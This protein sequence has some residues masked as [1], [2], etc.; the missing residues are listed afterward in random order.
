MARNGSG[1][2]IIP[3]TFNAGSTITSS[4]HNQNYTD[5]A[6]EIT[7]SLALDGQSTMTG[8]IKAANGSAGA[9]AY[10]FGSNLTTGFWRK[11]LN[12]IGIAIAGIEIGSFDANGLNLN[13]IALSSGQLTPSGTVVFTIKTV[14]PIGWLLFNDGTIGD[15]NSG[16]NHANADSLSV[17]TDLFN[18]ISDANCPIL[19]SIGAATTRVAQIDAATAWAAHCRITLPKSL[20]RALA[21]AGSGSGLTT[22]TLGATAGE[23]NHTLTQSE[24]SIALGTATSNSVVTDPGHYHTL[25][26]G[27]AGGNLQNGGTIINDAGAGHVAAAFT[28][29]S[30]TT[31]TT[32]TNSA[33]GN[34]HNNMQP[35]I[36]LNAMI[37]L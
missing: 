7:N 32:I 11:A 31:T 20:G 10:A 12:V 24:L 23:E 22:R 36:F 16:A 37:K 13:A 6:A 19:T 29:I 33:G 18:N 8:Q 28:N 5:I 1:T 26:A 2:E 30:V 9:P 35:T 17:F 4:G 27:G 21:A 25:G 3:N 14:S 34:A 15:A